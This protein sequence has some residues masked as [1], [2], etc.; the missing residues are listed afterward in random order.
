MKIEFNKIEK[1]VNEIYPEMV[2]W[3][4][5]IHANPELGDEEKETSE[6]VCSKLNE[7]NIQYMDKISGYGVKG[8]ILGQ[9]DEIGVGIRADMD[10]L[11][12][13][14]A[15]DCSFKSRNEGKM[16]ACGHDMHTAMLLGTAKVIDRIS[17]DFGTLPGNVAFFFEPAEETRGGAKGMIDEGCLNNPNISYTL[18]VHIA[19]EL[20]SGVIEFVKG[21]MCAASTMFK[22]TVKGK[23]CHGAHP[24]LGIDP[25]IP[26]CAMVTELQSIVTR[27]IH[28]QE[29]ALITVGSFHSG[30]AGNAIPD[31]TVFRGIIRVLDMKNRELLKEKLE[32]LCNGIAK[33]HGAEC[34]VEYED[35]YPVLYND[36]EMYRLSIETIMMNLGKEK[37]LQSEKA[38]MGAD[39]FAY[40]C[41]NSKGLY[42][43]LG[44][45]KE[46][47][48]MY[49]LHSS[50]LN[51]DE[52]AMKN[53]VL[54]EVLTVLKVLGVEVYNVKLY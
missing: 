21:S 18:G 13:L 35:S 34:V 12:I 25:L 9:S 16:H 6:F 50:N 37:V 8:V 28:P 7:M 11:P 51:P 3:R 10:A 4:R 43:S 39:D 24:Y 40:F 54:A 49:A 32:T 20:Q 44:T 27:N 36:D 19:A 26:A 17:S 14:E 5:H 2:E 22:V 29:S 30:S 41:E 15:T 1:I 53:G 31:E 46:G 33:A 42:L 45:H 47:E 38:S 52:N 23:S 48:E